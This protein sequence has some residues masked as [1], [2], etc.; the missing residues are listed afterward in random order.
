VARPFVHARV[1]PA[2]LPAGYWAV[3]PLA[4]VLV[5]TVAAFW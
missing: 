5:T 2:V 4:R 3:W 1:L